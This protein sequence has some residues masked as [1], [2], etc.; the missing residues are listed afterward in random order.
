MAKKP[1][2]K[3]AITRDL[4]TGEL[5]PLFLKPGTGR[6]IRLKRPPG[7]QTAIPGMA[8]FEGS[9]PEGKYCRDCF[10]LGDIPVTPPKGSLRTVPRIEHDACWRAKHLMGGQALPG[11][12][13][14]RRACKYFGEPVAK[15]SNDG[16][17]E[18]KT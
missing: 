15:E 9:G 7:E 13:G 5:R 11:G 3:V 4:F 16:Q 8:H 14:A 18:S 10:Y 1:K 6:H 17:D 2:P 12:L